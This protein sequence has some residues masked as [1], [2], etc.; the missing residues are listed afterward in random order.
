MN[1][2]RT[3]DNIDFDLSDC[4]MV[5]QAGRVLMTTPDHFDVTYVIN[6]HMEGNV[7][8]VDRARATLQWSRLR[9]TYATLGAAPMEIPGAEGHP[10]MVFCAN[11]TLPYYNPRSGERGVVLSRMHAPERRDEVSHYEAYFKRL[12]Y[13]IVRLPEGT[14]DFEGMGDALWHPGRY[15]LWGGSGFRT[16]DSVYEF[17]AGTLGVRVIALRLIDSD[18]YHLDTCLSLLDSDS[19]LYYPGA[20]DEDGLA[21][22]RHFFSNLIEA[23]E[24]EARELFACNAHSPDGEH[25]IIQQ[26]C[27]VTISR[28]RAAGFTPVA[29]NT[30]EYL[31]SGGSVFCMKQMIW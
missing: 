27:D 12:E 8:A 7:G 24:D 15:L 10:D 31:K 2:Y 11:Q 28:L 26:G 20:F 1:V 6:P 5:P 9:E 25:V 23:P 18:F 29:L 21:L 3:L 22:L 13:E 30:S 16:D 19:A 4:P 14:G 17:L